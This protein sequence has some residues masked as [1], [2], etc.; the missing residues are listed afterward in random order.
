L[1]K[2]ATDRAAESGG[3]AGGDI[4]R[5]DAATMEILCI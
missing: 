1:S 4:G 5:H 3:N 2:A